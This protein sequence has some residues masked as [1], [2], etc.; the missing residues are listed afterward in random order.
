MF[1]LLVIIIVILILTAPGACYRRSIGSQTSYEICPNNN[2]FPGVFSGGNV[3][4][5][6]NTNN[7][8]GNQGAYPMDASRWS[9]QYDPHLRG[10]GQR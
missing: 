7:A 10:D 2:A 3:F 1:Q 4:P 8:F 5:G 6:I 9:S